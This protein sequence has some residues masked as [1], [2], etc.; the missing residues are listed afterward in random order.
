MKLTLSDLDDLERGSG[1]S[2]DGVA[3]LGWDIWFSG[4]LKRNL[5]MKWDNGMRN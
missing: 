2:W 5:V 1:E 4:I 3:Y